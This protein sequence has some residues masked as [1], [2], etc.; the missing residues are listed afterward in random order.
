MC[1]VAFNDDLE[2]WGINPLWLENC[3]QNK[4]LTRKEFIED[5]MKKDAS[6]MKKEASEYWGEG[7]CARN[8]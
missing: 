1:V 4:F 5:E 6:L 3:C 8:R 7:T 2:F